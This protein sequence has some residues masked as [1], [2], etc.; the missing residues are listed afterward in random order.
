MKNLPQMPD[1]PE[2]EQTPL[3]KALLGI[4]EQYA[5]RIVLLEETVAGL[6][7]EINI[8]KGE[9]KRPTFKPSGMNESTGKTSRGTGARRT[10]GPDPRRNPRTLN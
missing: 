8:L 1:I 9:K 5:T 4:L 10:N 2:E 6:K 7:D 3:V